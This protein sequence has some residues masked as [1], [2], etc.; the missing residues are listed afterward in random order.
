MDATGTVYTDTQLLLK[1]RYEW[2]FGDDYAAKFG[3]PY[4]YSGDGGTAIS[5]FYRQPGFYT[6]TLTVSIWNQFTAGD[7]PIGNPIDV[8]ST[9][10]F[11]T[12]T[13]QPRRLPPWP[14]ADRLLDMRLDGNLIDSSP[15]ALQGHWQGGAGSFVTGVAGQAADL[16]SGAYISVTDTGVFSGLSQI[17]VSFWAKKSITTT[18]GYLLDK[19]GQFSVYISSLRTLGINLITSRGTARATSYL[20]YDVDNTHWHH[21]AF[22]YDGDAVR[23]FIDGKE[24][25]TLPYSGTVAY[26]TNN[27][28]IGRSAS[29]AAVFNGYI[30]ELRIY[31]RALSLNDLFVGFDLWHAPFQARTAQYIY[32]QIPSAAY[33]DPTNQLKVS[34]SGDNGYLATILDKSNLAA[35]EKFLFRNADLPTGTYTLTAQLLDAGNGVLDQMSEQFPKPYAGAPR[36]GIDENNSFRLNGQPFF[37]VTAWLLGKEDIASWKQNGYVN[38]LYA[39]GWYSSHSPATWADYLTQAANH[40]LDA[41][42][43]ERWFDLGLPVSLEPARRRHFARNA[44]I[45]VL[46]NYVTATRDLP[47]LAAWMWMDEPDLGGEVQRVPPAVLRAW[48]YA[49]HLSDPQHPVVTN[50]AGYD[51]LPYH[52]DAG[53]D[54]DFVNNA[55]IFSGKR[56][57]TV[58]A[59]GFDIYPLEYRR[60]TD[61]NQAD[62]GPLDL[63]VQALDRFAAKNSGLIPLL[64][65]V[66]VCDIEAANN[67]PAPTADQVLMEA[68]LNVVHGMKGI[69]WFHYFEYD[70]I[71]YSAMTKFTDQI[72]RLAPIVLGPEPDIHVIDSANVQAKRVDTLIRYH[73][74]YVYVFA[75]RLTEPDPITGS[76]YTISEP[77]TLNV[78]FQLD[79]FTSGLAE[80]VDENRT[81][82]VVGGTFADTFARNAVHIYKIPLSA[83]E[84]Q[85]TPGNHR[86]D[87]NWFVNVTL[88][89][90]STWRIA[91]YSQT[92]P[93]TIDNILSPTRAYP[94]TG[95]TNYAW[96]TVTLNAMLENSPLLTDTVRAMPTDIFVHLPLV[97]RDQ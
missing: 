13:G 44:N 18:Y 32:A 88:P 57:F 58:D 46:T 90:T 39:E 43:P 65:F 72:N 31:D 53:S 36:S 63:Y 27:L 41:F 91:Y 96:Y 66:E 34:V 71:R 25:V 9:T 50:L 12:V 49:S 77:P 80:V 81:V 20:A 10:T 76:L 42:G 78:N 33:R 52:G 11:I 48:T 92:V 8:A 6:V 17:S 29:V 67:T 47:A 94:L 86:I 61:L 84:L 75:V 7:L 70:T 56:Q 62:R 1:A 83:L 93:I 19:P 40:Q 22:T 28:L 26:S 37:P 14:D 85:G 21:Y 35:E 51:Y 45:N 24:L 74:G 95:L 82:T 23:T 15:S 4:Y 55:F 87:L 79:K 89:I 3:D 16:T 97:R 69:G 30:D 59:M 2:D 73:A 54:Y 5:H 68:W 64:S 60:R 38:S